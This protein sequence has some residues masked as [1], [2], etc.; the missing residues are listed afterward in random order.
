M[1]AEA[2]EPGTEQ[3]F[4]LAKLEEQLDPILCEFVQPTGRCGF[5]ATWHGRAV[6][7]AESAHAPFVCDT[8]QERIAAFLER[9]HMRCITCRALSG[10]VWTK[11]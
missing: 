6:C 3:L 11:L 9:H 7:H 8:H 10:V 1:T 2:Q 4:A 5:D